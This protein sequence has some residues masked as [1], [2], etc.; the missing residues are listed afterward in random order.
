M[1]VF[2]CLL[3]LLI[4]L[5]ANAQLNELDAKGRKQ[6]EWG[7]T[8]EGTRVYE[9]RGQFKDDKPVGKFTYFY[10]SSKVKAIINHDENSTRSE[11]YF[12]HEN[13][14]LMSYGIF[15]NELKDSVWVNFGPSQRL[16]NTETYS[17]GKLEGKKVIYYV[18]EILTDKSQIPSVLSYYKN[19]SLHGNYTEYFIDQRVKIQGQY[20]MN[21]KDGLWTHYHATGKPMMVIRYKKGVKHGWAMGYDDTGKEIAKKYFYYGRLL[22]GKQLAEKMRQLKELGVNPNE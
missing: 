22:E 7:K 1:N 3:I 10:K 2:N 15:R 20:H 5:S 11:A 21:T 9:Y 17:N 19:D 6:G 8:Y 13:G 4:S 14:A 18:P 12:Y 16:S